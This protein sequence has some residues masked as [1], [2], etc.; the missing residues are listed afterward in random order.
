VICC[1]VLAPC[2][3][4]QEQ[5]QKHQRRHEALVRQ[6]EELQAKLHSAQQ[7]SPASAWQAASFLMFFLVFINVWGLMLNMQWGWGWGWPWM[8]A[9]KTV[10]ATSWASLGLKQLL[11]FV[12]PLTNIAVVLIFCMQAVKAAWTCLKC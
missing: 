7:Q 10:A 8:P 3:A 9:A 5:L 1:C 11:N 6:I 12:V 4:L 2:S